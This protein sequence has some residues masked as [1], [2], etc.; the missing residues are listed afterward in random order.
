MNA[1]RLARLEDA[2]LRSWCQTQESRLA[3]PDSAQTFIDRAGIATLYP[4]S[5]EIPNLFHAYTGDP[6][7]TTDAGHDTPSGRVY[8]WRWELGSREVGYF[9]EVVRKRPTWVSRRLLPALLRLRADPRVPRR[10]YEAG[11][12]STGAL[13]IAEALQS[14]GEPVSTGELRRLA[15]FPNGTEQ[16]KTFLKAVAELDSLLITTRAFSSATT[17]TFYCLTELTYPD[18]A[19][20]SMSMSIEEGIRAF[21]QMY[22]SSALYIRPQTVAKHLGISKQDLLTVL[23]ELELQGQVEK[24]EPSGRDEAVYIWLPPT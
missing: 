11:G 1:D 23:E 21:L 14:A 4:A 19:R 7:S 2:R 13:R 18:A 3:T 10:L 20:Q 6:S 22:L 16:R 15:G 9:G 12:I 8:A 5:A 17:D 24:V